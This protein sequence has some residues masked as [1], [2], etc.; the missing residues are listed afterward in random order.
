MRICKSVLRWL[1]A[2]TLALI[3][4]LSL[5]FPAAAD[6]GTYRLSN[7]AVTLEPQSDGRVK[8]TCEQDWVVLSGD[9]PWVTV[10]LPNAKYEILDYSGN[11]AAVTA[12]NSGGWSG[13]NIDL[14]RDYQAGDTFSIKFSVLQSNLLERLV[15]QNIWRI[16]YTPGWYDRAVIDRLQIVLT[17][18][19][20]VQ[21]YSLVSPSPS[22]ASTGTMTW[23]RTNLSPG[24]KVSIKVECQDGSFLTAAAAANT[25]TSGTGISGTTVIIIIGVII[26]VTLLVL[27]GIRKNREAKEEELNR[28]VITIESEMATDA[29]KKEEIE[30][31][32]QKYVE[33]EKI[34]PDEQGRYYDAHYGNY[35]TP[36]IW[37][38]MIMPQGSSGSSTGGYKSSRTGC[39]CACVSCACACACACAG[40]GAAGCSRKSLHECEQC[41]EGNLK[42]KDQ[43]S[44]PKPVN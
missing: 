20:D 7:Y 32:F 25:G 12:A 24:D 42:L 3:I 1:S 17:S 34:R 21:S 43:N 27:W 41:R 9:I 2:G 33:K 31:G 10:G 5:A 40:G 4:L 8:I 29:K 38:A 44:S 35:I 37:A 36:I 6:T 13:V 26:I 30:S 23:E 19:A 16:D 18:P 11:A 39:A 15:S 22:S 14:E 28:R